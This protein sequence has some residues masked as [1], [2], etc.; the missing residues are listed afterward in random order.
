MSEY[1]YEKC[2]KKYVS[3][4][5]DLASSDIDLV[6]GAGARGIMMFVHTVRP[7]FKRH[8]PRRPR[9]TDYIMVVKTDHRRNLKHTSGLTKPSTMKMKKVVMS[10]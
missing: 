3:I 6:V 10:I 1:N 8:L 4:A 9:A 7:K 5:M 2:K